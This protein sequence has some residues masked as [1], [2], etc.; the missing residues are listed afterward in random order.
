[1]SPRPMTP[2]HATVYNLV[3]DLIGD[4]LS[5][6]EAKAEAAR[7]CGV[8]RQVVRNAIKS[9]ARQ[10]HLSPE[11]GPSTEPLPDTKALAEV[12]SDANYEVSRTITNREWIIVRE[13]GDY[14]AILAKAKAKAEAAKAAYMAAVEQVAR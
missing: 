12:W 4:G 8:S 13:G 6:A 1:M 3:V 14:E 9:A 11:A 2:V 5:L 10:P 7:Q